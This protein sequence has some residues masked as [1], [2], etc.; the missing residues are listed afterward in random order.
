MCAS[1][2]DRE[3]GL[4]AALRRWFGHDG[5][6]EG[7][8]EV[9]RRVLAG[10]DVCV[11]MPTGAGKSLCYQ[12]PALMRP[13]YGLVVSPLISLMKDQVDGLRARGIAAA[14]VNSA[15]PLDGQRAAFRGVRDGTVRI[16]YV[17][18]ERFRIGMFLRLLEDCRPALLV[19]DEAHCIS[20][21]GHDFR[22]DYLALGPAAESLGIPQ[23]CA[24]TATAT[25]RVRE[26]IRD[27]LR[28]PGMRVFVSGFQRPNLAFAVR[29]CAN[30]GAKDALL[31]GLFEA[32]EPAIVYTATR[33]NAERIA[34]DL[35][36]ICYHAGLDTGERHRAQQRF[37]AESCPVLVA[38]NAFGMGI[39][40]ADIRRVI[41]Y[42]LPGSLEAYYQEAGRAGRDGREAT[43]LLLYAYRDRYIQETLIDLNNPSEGQLRSVYGTVHALCRQ[44]GARTL[45]MT[46]AE[47]A[48]LVP[49]EE[50]ERSIGS[51]LRALEKI[52]AVRR[53]YRRQ[54]TGELRLL[55]DPAALRRIHQHE[56][57]QRS[58]FLFRLASRLAESGASSGRFTV[59]QLGVLSGLRPD[60]VRRVLRA[61]QDEVLAWTPPFAGGTVELL[62]PEVT[63]PAIDGEA[64][65]RK[66]AFE[67]ERLEEV[68]AYTR[69]SACRQVFLVSYFGQQSGGWRCGR[70][71]L[72]AGRGGRER[73]L[74][75][76][77]DASVRAILT[78]VSSLAGSFGRGRITAMLTADAERPPGPGMLQDHPQRGSLRHLGE[79]GVRQLLE[80]LA[81]ADCID[82]VGDPAYP[83][84]ALSARGRRVLGRQEAL[85]LDLPPTGP[86]RAKQGEARPGRA[87]RARP[88]VADAALLAA[89]QELRGR[90]AAARHVAAYRILS[91]AVLNEL[92]V[93]RPR[94]KEQALAIRGI[95]R[96]K[97]ETVVPLFL[98][99]IQRREG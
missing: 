62:D 2:A 65:E 48:S 18:P 45:E 39:D 37:M 31:R 61:L 44:R 70:C 52:G 89:L 16:L 73:E 59:E 53:G 75:A 49:G 68:L 25:P 50:S 96:L 94:T 85:L 72:C 8:E 28:R 64:I 13:G 35:G 78:A 86:Q 57:T 82:T 76:G 47:L 9:I 71:D 74:S 66:R 58:R 22:P 40:R 30:D 56:S 93:Q 10:D 42:H 7:Q 90:L 84:I 21:W 80:A 51:C 4:G 38:T 69:T 1:S 67:L 20:Q 23:V 14:C 19:V 97:A 43:C 17:A 79:S 26:D 54:A 60:Q 99:E 32:P 5:F 55:G 3:D 33:K 98:A 41:H 83:C 95:G 92:A 88:A 81:R 36:C 15:I 34:G 27:R 91:N 24:F 6:R 77:E 87:P 29:E 12:L 46:H 63:T 11:V